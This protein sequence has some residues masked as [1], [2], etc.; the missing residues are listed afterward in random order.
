MEF[1]ET[2]LIILLIFVGLRILIKYLGPLL[3]KFI[4][5]RFAKKMQDKFNQSQQPQEETNSSQK[6]RF[7]S[8][9]STKKSK[10]QKV[11]EYIDYEEID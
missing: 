4:M 1:L 6:T 3:L 7:K 10:N 11:G 2:V 8:K 9:T 5:K